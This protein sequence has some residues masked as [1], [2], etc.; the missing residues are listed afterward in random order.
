VKRSEYQR[1]IE[2]WTAQYLDR[3]GDP[4]PDQ[5]EDFNPSAFKLRRCEKCH[6]P[7]RTME[8]HHKGH[9]FL[10]AN[11]LPN[12][13]AKR[14]LQ[15]HPDDIAWLCHQCHKNETC[16]SKSTVT[17]II[18]EYKSLGRMSYERCEHHRR[19][20]VKLFNRWVKQ[21]TRRRSRGP[22]VT[23]LPT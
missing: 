19:Q 11:I 17:R 1:Q 4:S 12:R 10:F 15:F 3:K 2:V 22:T 16:Y 14:Y 18:T 5:A 23:Q 7:K 13:Y 21:P 8:R 6:K 20:L 9:E